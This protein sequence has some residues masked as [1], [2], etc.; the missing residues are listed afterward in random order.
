MHFRLWEFHFVWPLIIPLLMT[1]T[2][3]PFKIMNKILYFFDVLIFGR[4]KVQYVIHFIY[5][6]DTHFL[7][8]RFV[9]VK[10]NF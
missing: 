9:R 8:T 3:C 2:N 6:L 5:S 7:Y 1:K 4:R 10:K